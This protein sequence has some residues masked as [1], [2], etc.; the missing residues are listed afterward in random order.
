M[1]V[2]NDT[3]PPADPAV[4]SIFVDAGNTYASSPW[5][6]SYMTVHISPNNLTTDAVILSHELGHTLGLYHTHAK[7]EGAVANPNWPSALFDY[8]LVIRQ[9]IT[10]PADPRPHKFANCA[11]ICAN[12]SPYP[13]PN[14]MFPLDVAA[15]DLL[16][17][18]PA[19]PSMGRQGIVAMDGCKYISA[20]TDANGDVYEPMV[21]KYHVLCS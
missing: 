7:T 9:D 14:P 8:E 1:T 19:D 15:G 12:E 11:F 17:D 5:A 3:F 20:E 6:G 21:R 2:V 16:C 18:T 13:Q 4:L 10:D